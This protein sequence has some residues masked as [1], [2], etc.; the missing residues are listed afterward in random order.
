MYRL[1]ATDIDDTIL[2]PD[3]SL[4]ETNRRALEKL[5]SRGVPVVFSS[6][7]ATVAMRHLV[8]RILPL[9][10][11][12]FIISYNG[13]RVVQAESDQVLFERLI[14]QESVREIAAY[15]REHNLLVHGYEPV[16]FLVEVDDPRSVVYAEDTGMS[17][18]KVE[19]MADLLPQG[20]PK[21]LVIGPHEELVKHREELHRRSRGRWSSTFS[22]PHYLEVMSPGVSKGEALKRL[23][24]HLRIPIA[25][26]VA[27]GD[28]LNDSEMLQTAG[29]GV[30]VANAREQLKA[31]ADVILER[32]AAQGAIEELV[33]R[34]FP[35]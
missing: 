31:V 20:S 2:A 21:L 1:L 32:T 26:T 4:P 6:G 11:D 22:K 30:A 9:A 8:K 29:L 35:E 27:A 24:E 5:H 17:Y 3:G 25:E 12:E 16:D 13:A 28:S 14:D 7:R 33:E 10:D 34:F 18:R 19:S 23:A 15:G